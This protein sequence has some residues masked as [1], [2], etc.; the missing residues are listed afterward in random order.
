MAYRARILESANRELGDIVASL[1]GYS[2]SAARCFLEEYETQLD[3]IC[4]E[5]VSYGLSRMPELAQL[6][7]RCALVG[8]HLLL[9]YI[10]GDCVV[11]AHLF[12]QRQDYAKLVGP[13]RRRA[14]D[15]I[16]GEAN[17]N[18]GG[19]SAPETACPTKP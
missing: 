15:N 6:G 1:A 7:Y 10:E 4:S 2:P 17:S 14:S 13:K 5:T 9:Y 8:K 12:H 16:D 11:V 19:Q 3:L 18:H